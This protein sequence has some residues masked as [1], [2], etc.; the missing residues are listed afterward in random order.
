M[1]QEPNNKDIRLSYFYNL[2]MYNKKIKKERTEYKKQLINKLHE[3]HNYNPKLFWETVSKLKN[4]GKEKSKNN[5]INLRDWTQHFANLSKPHPSTPSDES[6]KKDIEQQEKECNFNNLDFRFTL[7][8]PW[9]LQRA[10]SIQLC[11]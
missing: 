6:V 3:T 2:K 4:L 7:E 1:S 9:Q 5:P 11:W 10:H 8:E